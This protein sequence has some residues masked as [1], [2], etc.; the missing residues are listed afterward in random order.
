MPISSEIKKSLADSR[1]PT[2]QTIR[3]KSEARGQG[4]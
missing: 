4:T 3:F 1:T 2:P